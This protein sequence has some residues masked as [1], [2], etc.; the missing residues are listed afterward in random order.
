MIVIRTEKVY[1]IER[2]GQDSWKVPEFLFC[3][4]EKE[5]E[6]V[7]LL[8]LVYRILL[9]YSVCVLLSVCVCPSEEDEEEWSSAR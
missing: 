6:P 8:V 1:S 5:S 9:Q 2:K 7:W 3:L 4:V